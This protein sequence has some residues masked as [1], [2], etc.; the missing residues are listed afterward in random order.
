ME[1]LLTAKDVMEKLRVSRSWIAKHILSTAVPRLGFVRVGGQL[2]FTEEHLQQYLALVDRAPSK[3]DW[4]SV[5]TK[6]RP[7]RKV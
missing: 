2:R 4:V 6:Q 7:R 5:T 1:K 3:A